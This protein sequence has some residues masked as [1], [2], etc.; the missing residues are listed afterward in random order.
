MDW[1]RVVDEVTTAWEG[2]HGPKPLDR[3]CIRVDSSTMSAIAAALATNFVHRLPPP[4]IALYG[5]LGAGK[6]TFC[7]GFINALIPNMAV[8]S[9]TF[10]LIHPYVLNEGLT[11]NAPLTLYHMDLYRIESIHQA[12]AIGVEEYFYTGLCLVEWP[13]VVESLFPPHHIKVS[14]DFISGHEDERLL[15]IETSHV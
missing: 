7:Q 3:W 5:D 9:P 12:H 1:K 6:T 4:T 8:H 13:Q 14:I 11:K 15:C 10:S 2:G